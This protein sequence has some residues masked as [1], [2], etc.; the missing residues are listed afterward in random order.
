MKHFRNILILLMLFT[1][2]MGYAQHDLE[3]ARKEMSLYNYSKAAEI[4]HKVALK[5]KGRQSCE[6]TILLAE[7]YRMLNDV[8]GS[9]TWYARAVE[10]A[11]ECKSIKNSGPE[12]YFHYAQALRSSGEYAK[13]REM[14][15]RYDSL[16]GKL[17]SG[18]LFSGYCDSAMTWLTGKPGFGIRNM[19]TLNTPQ[20]DFGITLFQKG[21]VFASDR[22]SAG[23]TRR[24]Y[25]WTGNNFISLYFTQPDQPDSLHGNFSIPAPF[26]GFPDM[27]WHDGPVSFN[28]DF[29]KVFINR[30]QMRHDK[31]KKEPGMTRTHLLKIFISDKTD[32]KWSQPES[33]YLNSDDYSVGHPCISSD[34][35]TLYFVSDM[36]GG[37]GETDIWFCR[38][39]STRWSAPINAGPAVNTP[40]KEMF[41][42]IAVN[43]DLIFASDTRPGFGGLDLFVVANDDRSTSRNLGMPINSSYDDF[44]LIQNP[45]QQGGLFSSNRPGGAGSDDLYSFRVLTPETPSTVSVV[46]TEPV[47]PETASSDTLKL[48]KTYRLENI[49]Y[50]FDKW[51]IR[52]DAKPSL[53]KLVTIMKE[54]PVSIELG[55]H[56]DCRGTADYNLQL[57]QKRAE[58]A[59]QYIISQGISSKRIAAKGYGKSQLLND[60]N[61]AAGHDC[62]EQAHQHN[63]RTEFKIIGINPND[64]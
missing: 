50:D 21:Y 3:N 8:A 1:G 63:R 54:Y 41:P 45:D 35:K 13:A 12:L 25:G 29:N 47:P 20:S 9:K 43:G 51:D 27:A 32:G 61:C 60:C 31:G 39:D 53:D 10:M 14:F 28:H 40:G 16:G 19:A 56:T 55:S 11:H 49:L 4:L 34:G 44:A 23:N 5:G 62:A 2:A 33:F 48:D 26:S 57:S 46:K 30:T 52:A 36:P 37:L 42:H 58:S 64:H 18:A 7:C 59:V 17:F 24:T 22:S 38:L 15:L 6:A